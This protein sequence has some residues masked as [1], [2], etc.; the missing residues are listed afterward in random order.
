M[1]TESTQQDIEVIQAWTS[2]D[3]YHKDRNDPFWWLTGEG[4]LAFKWVDDDGT[5]FYLRG[6]DNE[7]LF[8]ISIQFGPEEVVSKKRLVIGMLN[9]WP[10]MVK[11]AQDR[12]Y[13]GVVFTSVS[14]KLVQF[15]HKPPFNYKQVEGTDDH[16]LVFEAR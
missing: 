7:N 5:V 4:L 14:P 16:V 15:M 9:A 1:F 10:M 12:G 11:F 2:L 3:P 6:D 8:R 13:E